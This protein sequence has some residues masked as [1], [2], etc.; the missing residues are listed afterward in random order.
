ML[1]LIQ[2]GQRLFPNAFVSMLVFPTSNH[3]PLLLKFNLIKKVE[4][5]AF[6]HFDTRGLPMRSSWRLLMECES[7]VIR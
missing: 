3:D 7:P 1:L 5:S 4:M 6:F 2:D